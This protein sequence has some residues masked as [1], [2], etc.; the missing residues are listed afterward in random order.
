[1]API[2]WMALIQW[3]KIRAG[4]SGPLFGFVDA[5]RETKRAV[6]IRGEYHSLEKT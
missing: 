3:D 2:F 4:V 1:M 5:E 6:Q